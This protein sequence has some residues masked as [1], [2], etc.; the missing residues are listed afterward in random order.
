M[1]SKYFP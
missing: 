1:I